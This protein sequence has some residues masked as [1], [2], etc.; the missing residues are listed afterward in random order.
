MTG[1]LTLREV[2]AAAAAA[3]PETQAEQA[4][5]RKCALLR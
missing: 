4:L 5:L 3:S 1:K 2:L